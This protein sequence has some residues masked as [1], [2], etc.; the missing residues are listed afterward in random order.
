MHSNSS[1][2]RVIVAGVFLWLWL[3]ASPAYA[4]AGILL[5]GLGV[6]CLLFGNMIIGVGEGWLA[7][8]W[9]KLR[10][11]RTIGIFILANY[12][13]MIAGMY[14]FFVLNEHFKNNF[15]KE[16]LVYGGVLLILLGLLSWLLSVV[17]E[18][19]FCLWAVRRSEGRVRRATILSLG[20]QTAS[21]AFLIPVYLSA[22]TISLYTNGRIF[23][24]TRFTKNPK[25][26]LYYVEKATR[27]VWS[28]KLDGSGNR[29][30]A[31]H[32]VP[33]RF[34]SLFLR[35]ADGKVEL[36]AKDWGNTVKLLD[37]V[38]ASP[39]V[40]ERSQSRE[41]QYP[42]L[43]LRPQNERAWKVINYSGVD[44]IWSI[45]GFGVEGPAD[46]SGS[47]NRYRLALKTPVLSAEWG[48]VTVLPHDE[49]V[50]QINDAI[51]LIH[52][53]SRRVGFLTEG[54]APVVVSVFDQP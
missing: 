9:M 44:S 54:E 39:M 7:A 28:I 41:N 53:P 12:L 25:V 11:L 16:V 33:E 42:A 2:R 51:V 52:V 15:S 45:S 48:N 40:A 31:E 46:N 20:V 24:D 49:A 14:L 10:T 17:V 18:W 27:D 32:V 47:P 13:S 26:E 8:R 43:D 38:P 6:G 5:I 29:R 50:A 35:P 19:P 22:G 21:Y 3:T 36:W 37:E 23:P 30:V 34:R 1:S 4:D